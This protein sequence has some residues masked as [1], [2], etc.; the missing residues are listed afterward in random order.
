MNVKNIILNLNKLI[1]ILLVFHLYDANAQEGVLQIRCVDSDTKESV[2]NANFSLLR[3]DTLEY[4]SSNEQGLIFLNLNKDEVYFTEIQHGYYNSSKVK[5]TLSKASKD[6][7]TTKLE[8]ILKKSKIHEIQEV[9]AAAPGVPVVVFSSDKYSVS[10]FE[11]LPNAEILLLVYPKTL[12]KG[13]ELMLIKGSEILKTFQVKEKPIELIHD[14]RGNPHIVCES[15]VYG[16]QRK[17][18]E[19]G[20]ST[21]DKAYFMKYIFPIVDTAYSKLYFSTY[22]KDYPAF[23]YF[24][25]DQIDSAYT[26][27]AAIKDDLMMELYRS[28][29]KWVDVRTKLWAKEQEYLTGIDKEIWVGANYFTQS[30][31]YKELY[32]PMFHRNDSIFVFDYYKDLLFTYDIHGNK[33]DSIAIFHHYQPKKTGWKQKLLQDPETKQIYAFFEKDGICSIKWLNTK[34]GQLG[35]K[36]ILEHKYV[37]KIAIHG[38]MAYY[39]YRPFESAQKKFLYRSKLPVSFISKE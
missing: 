1:L 14:F 26:K 29:Y 11:M 37:D 7:D 23:D 17:E 15:G 9:I 6:L 12:A 2:R 39:I 16:V 5:F 34:T 36:M 10:D 32:A 18:G 4:Y 33:L 25:F 20:I 24:A 13:G 19:I 28:E 3:N 30:I 27:I 38:N 35:E 22:N 8:V 31:Y 21:Y